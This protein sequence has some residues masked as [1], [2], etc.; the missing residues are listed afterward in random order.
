VGWTPLGGVGAG[1]A[2]RLCVGARVAGGASRSAGLVLV[3]L[4]SLFSPETVASDRRGSFEA[5]VLGAGACEGAGFVALTVV[6][7]SPWVPASV[8]ISA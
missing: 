6:P 5:S 7:R 8:P 1:A 3:V 4:G 2:G